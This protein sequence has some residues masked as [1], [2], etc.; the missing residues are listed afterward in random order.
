MGVIPQKV[1]VFSTNKESVLQPLYSKSIPLD[2]IFKKDTLD[3][4]FKKDTK[5]TILKGYRIQ[6]HMNT[7]ERIY[8]N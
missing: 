3:I 6:K 5:D 2:I 4:I 1:F 8:M 7:N